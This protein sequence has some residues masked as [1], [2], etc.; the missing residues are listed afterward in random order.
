[1]VLYNGI[2]LVSVGI[3]SSYESE[4]N[5]NKR[6]QLHHFEHDRLHIQPLLMFL[7]EL[8]YVI[9]ECACIQSGLEEHDKYGEN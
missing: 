3:A 1:M 7:F 8:H 5:N 9:I 4:A 6:D 2:I